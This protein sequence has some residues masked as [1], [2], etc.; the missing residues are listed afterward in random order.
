MRTIGFTLFCAALGAW[1]I[2]AI[3]TIME[4]RDIQRG[5][6]AS[7]LYDEHQERREGM[8]CTTDLDC[9]MKYNDC[10]EDL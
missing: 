5:H 9:C 6:Y 10:D 4:R 8:Q 1:M 3:D 7:Q 2:Y